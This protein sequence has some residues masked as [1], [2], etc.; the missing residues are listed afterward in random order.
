M[1]KRGR[2]KG[3]K[4]KKT[5]PRTKSQD[6]SRPKPPVKVQIDPEEALLQVRKRKRVK[7]PACPA[8]KSCD[9][10]VYSSKKYPSFMTNRQMKLY[11]YYKCGECGHNFKE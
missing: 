9:T 8:C 7:G 2:P 10:F 6:M 5:E 4:N 3:S 11:R 1:G